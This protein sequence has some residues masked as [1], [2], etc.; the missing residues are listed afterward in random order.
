MCNRYTTPELRAIEYAWDLGST[1]PLFPRREVFPRAP[2]LFIRKSKASA[3]A[4]EGVIGRWGLVPFFAK[5]VDLPYSTNN[6]RFEELSSKP[7][8][9]DAWRK[10]Q[11]CIIPAEEFLEPCWETG[12]NVWWKFR[13]ADGQPFALAGLWNTWTDQFT[14]EQFETYTM[15]TQNADAS[16][17]MSRMH[18]P[19][20]HLP[21]DKQ[22][23]RSVVVLDKSDLDA[24][25][26]GDQTQAA[27]CVRV[28]PDEL[29]EAAPTIP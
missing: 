24:W 4:A 23:K 3:H 27:A 18:R 29:F 25:L 12:K 16:P 26:H 21:P 28:A 7:T 22:D 19:D 6:A 2:G 17:L 10:G 15:L 5:T 13:R 1:L 9:R 8:F 20:P 11:R 14:G